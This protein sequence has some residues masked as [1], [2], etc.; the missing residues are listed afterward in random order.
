[1]LC[2]E[3]AIIGTCQPQE[4]EKYPHQDCQGWV[5]LKNVFVLSQTMFVCK[6]GSETTQKALAC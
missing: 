5:S 3:V 1:M 6:L 2:K 4:E